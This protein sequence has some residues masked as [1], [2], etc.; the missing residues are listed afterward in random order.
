MKDMHTTLAGKMFGAFV[1]AA[2]VWAVAI[3][4]PVSAGDA[5]ILFVNGVVYTVDADDSVAE[6]LAVQGDRIV[7]VG[8]AA[9]A[10]A[11]RKA[12]TEV[13]D[14]A[15]GML[16]PGF[17]DNHIHSP[18]PLVTD[19]FDFSLFGVYG[20]EQ[21]LAA[22]EK[23]VADNP[24]NALYFGIGFATSAFAGDEA[25]KGPKKERLDQICPDKPMFIFS[26][27]GHTLWLNSKA[28]KL[29]GITRDTPSPKG[30]VIEKNPETGELWGAVKDTA[31]ML[32][33]SVDF[34]LERWVA[35]PGRV[36]A[37]DERLG[38]HLHHVHRG[39]CPHHGG[40]SLRGIQ[41]PGKGGSP[42]LADGRGRLP[43]RR[44]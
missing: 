13:V 34:P 11:Y 4:S 21:T 24:D 12:E 2:C 5:D 22:I 1:L 31:M 38:I 7:F 33:N 44:R 18:G 40:G 42:D 6:A 41:R 15:G 23:V 35:G 27:D 43:C 9:A 3:N 37:D 8:S 16:L 36:P 10:Q 28:F 17:S 20:A 25:A 29:C 32:V 39:L 14:L 30:G 19:L 26:N